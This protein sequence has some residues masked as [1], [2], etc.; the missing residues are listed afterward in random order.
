MHRYLFITNITESYYA[1]GILLGVQDTEVN[2]TGEIATL[3][4][5]LH[6]GRK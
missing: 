3:R 1:I 4:E 5:L 6:Q 2:K